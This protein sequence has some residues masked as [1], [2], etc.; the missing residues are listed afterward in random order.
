MNTMLL[1]DN[2]SYG[3]F[4]YGNNFSRLIKY[5]KLRLQVVLQ[6]SEVK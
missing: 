2:Y 3:K 1:Q 5:Y 6:P 4:S